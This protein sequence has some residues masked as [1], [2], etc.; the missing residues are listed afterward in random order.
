MLLNWCYTYASHVNTLEL[1]THEEI[2][3]CVFVELTAHINI[4]KTNSSPYREKRDSIEGHK[5]NILGSVRKHK[6]NSDMSS[7]PREW[8]K[9][10]RYFRVLPRIRTYM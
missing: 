7:Q 5:E 8:A 9:Q 10:Y 3:E 4:S 6:E 1:M 2:L